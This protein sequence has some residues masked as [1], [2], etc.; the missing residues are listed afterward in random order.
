MPAGA[1]APE[2]D[3]NINKNATIGHFLNKVAEQTNFDISI[4]LLHGGKIT[5]ANYVL[6]SRVGDG[7]TISILTEPWLPCD[8][9]RHTHTQS[10]AIEGKVVSTLL[11]E[12]HT[13]WDTDLIMDI[14]DDREA[15]LILANPVHNRAADSW[16]RNKEKSGNYSVKSAY[17]V[18][19]DSRNSGHSSNN[20]GFWRRMWNL[21]ILAKIKHFLWSASTNCLPT[22]DRLRGKRVNVNVLCPMCNDESESTMHILTTCCFAMECFTNIGKLANVTG[23]NGFAEWLKSAFDHFHCKTLN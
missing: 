17:I 20:L 6:V 1:P 9:D 19:Q 16:Y 13:Q 3:C 18:L 5:E 11:N 22:K 4:L 10:P 15:N 23:V 12:E 7:S 2:D 14:F 8:S 21:K